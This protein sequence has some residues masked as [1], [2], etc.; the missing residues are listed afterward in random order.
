MA[1]TSCKKSKK[2]NAP[3]FCK[4]W[5]FGLILKRKDPRTRMFVS[6]T[7]IS[8]VEKHKNKNKIQK[9]N[10]IK[11]Q[12]KKVTTKRCNYNFKSN[13]NFKLV[14]KKLLNYYYL[15]RSSWTAYCVNFIDVDDARCFLTSL[16]E[17]ITNSRR[18]NTWNKLN[19]F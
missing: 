1:I 11:T 8:W 12:T 7:F 10:K 6:L 19:A 9:T 17:Q 14:F 13:Y 18:T 2:F 5:T 4:T 16:R 15:R 3:I